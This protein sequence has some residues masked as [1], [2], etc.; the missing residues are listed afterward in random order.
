MHE[1]TPRDTHTPTPP[2]PMASSWA[3]VEH[4]RKGAPTFQQATSQ[5]QRR[6]VEKTLLETGWNVSE[7]ARRLGLARSHVYNLIRT[8][9]LKRATRGA[10]G[11]IGRLDDPSQPR[12]AAGSGS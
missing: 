6:F 4:G 5:F 11:G 1:S 9:G 8:F 3:E 12:R 2:S 7:A 10:D